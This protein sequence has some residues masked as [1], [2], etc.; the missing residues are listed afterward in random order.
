MNGRVKFFKEDRG[1]GFIVRDD[2]GRDVFVHRDDLPGGMNF[3]HDD[4]AVSFEIEETTHGDRARKVE[5]L[6]NGADNPWKQIEILA[7]EIDPTL[8]ADLSG[9]ELRI[10]LSRQY[11]SVEAHARGAGRASDMKMESSK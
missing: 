4:Q 9:Y 6:H 2:G 10:T 1:Y 11:Q 3:L 7:R 8:P 5:L